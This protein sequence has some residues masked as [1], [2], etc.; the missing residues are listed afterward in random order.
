M[1]EGI[2]RRVFFKRI[3]KTTVNIPVIILSI[4]KPINGFKLAIYVPRKISIAD[5]LPMTQDTLL[6]AFMPKNPPIMSKIPYPRNISCTV[7][8][9]NTPLEIQKDFLH[10]ASL[11]SL[12]FDNI[13]RVYHLQ[14]SEPFELIFAVCAYFLEQPPQ[15]H[16]CD[17]AL[18]LEF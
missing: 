2:K 15:A 10:F 3:K 4:E 1:P 14:F 11:F 9:I 18:H 6:P 12:F 8:I 7:D 16:Q 17:K 5:I 13:L